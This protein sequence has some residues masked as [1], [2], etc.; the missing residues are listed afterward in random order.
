MIV[1]NGHLYLRIIK[2]GLHIIYVLLCRLIKFDKTSKIYKKNPSIKF[3][4]FNSRVF[5]FYDF[6][7]DQMG[8]Y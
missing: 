1:Q 2:Y 8:M 5:F 7:K 3:N 6:A 4:N